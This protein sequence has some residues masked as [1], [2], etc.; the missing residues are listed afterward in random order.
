MYQQQFRVES[1]KSTIAIVAID[2]DGRH[3]SQFISG[4]S[5]YVLHAK[6]LWKFSAERH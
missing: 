3:V 4:L 2:L 5:L 6:F 1:A